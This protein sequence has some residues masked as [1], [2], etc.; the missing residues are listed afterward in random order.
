MTARWVGSAYD[1]AAQLHF[2]R[3]AA[4]ARHFDQY[5][6]GPGDANASYALDFVKEIDPDSSLGWRKPTEPTPPTR[7]VAFAGVTYDRPATRGDD[8]T[9]RIA[10]STAA[11]PPRGTFSGHAAEFRAAKFAGTRTPAE[12]AADLAD[13]TP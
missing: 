9:M 12:R 2:D 10:N 4:L 11:D 5:W 8:G 13:E 1:V 6:I 3:R 7:P